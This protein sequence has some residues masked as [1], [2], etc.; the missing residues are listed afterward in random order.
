MKEQG[1]GGTR[2]S[3]GQQ[4]PPCLL[5]VAPDDIRSGTNHI[6]TALDCT[7]TKRLAQ[8]YHVRTP[9]TTPLT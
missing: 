3:H 5:S 2:A 1:R 6:C 4:S 9:F 7:A 8:L